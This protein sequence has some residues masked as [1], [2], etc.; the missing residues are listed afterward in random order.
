M[1]L[2]ISQNSQGNT[3]T[4]VSFLNA[5]SNF[6]NEETQVFQRHSVFQ[7]RNYFREKPDPKFRLASKYASV[8]LPC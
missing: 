7:S 2:K 4:G 8:L 1:F 6:I 5:A 3:C